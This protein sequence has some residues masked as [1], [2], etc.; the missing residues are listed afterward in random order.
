[1]KK[2]ATKKPDRR[3]VAARKTSPDTPAD[4]RARKSII[5]LLTLTASAGHHLRQLDA[6][7]VTPDERHIIEAVRA[8]VRDVAHGLN[9]TE[10]RRC[11]LTPAAAYARH[12][13]KPEPELLRL[14]NDMIDDFERTT[15]AA[16]FLVGLARGID[17][18]H[19]HR[20]FV[21]LLAGAID[22]YIDGGAR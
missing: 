13:G 12:A 19:K 2:T 4:R 16:G 1:M 17:W 18:S 14:V 22:H 8:T 15:A 7:S 5:D 3:K 9:T 20:K 11:L 10:L 6:T 21:P